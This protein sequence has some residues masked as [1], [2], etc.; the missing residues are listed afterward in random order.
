MN[1]YKIKSMRS[2]ACFLALLASFPV[3]A[4]EFEGGEIVLPEVFD[5]IPRTY[6]YKNG[7]KHIF[8]KGHGYH[9]GGD[10]QGFIAVIRLGFT[11][12][13]SKGSARFSKKQLEHIT[14]TTLLR[15]LV[16]DEEHRENVKRGEIEHIVISGQPA[17]RMYWTSSW[18]RLDIEEYI[19]S[20]VSGA[21]VYVFQAGDLMDYKEEGN[22]EEARKSI[23]RIR[24]WVNRDN[25]QEVQNPGA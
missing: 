9:Y 18:R 1:S 23:E 14:D 8:S 4:Y 13:D 12:G 22:L 19:Y 6:H 16:Q 21:N 5:E 7:E 10:Y 25:E 24:L 17:S 11:G 2:W 3:F 15:F 20:V